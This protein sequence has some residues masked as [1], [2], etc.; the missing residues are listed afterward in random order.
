MSSLTDALA[1][2]YSPHDGATPA[3]SLPPAL[4]TAVL[5]K[6]ASL[7]A[8]LSAFDGDDGAAAEAEND[9]VVAEVTTGA[10]LV[11]VLLA[12]AETVEES[13]AVAAT[14]AL[15][16]LV[17]GMHGRLADVGGTEGDVGSRTNAGAAAASSVGLAINSL[18]AR[19]VEA[20]INQAVGLS[21]AVGDGGSSAP[22]PPLMLRSANLN[23]TLTVS[24]PGALGDIPFACDTA[25]TPVEV[26]LP[27]GMIRLLSAAGQGTEDE[28]VGVVFTVTNLRV[29]P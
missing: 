3:A 23:L 24:E 18:G 1:L 15:N 10:K 22:P 6:V 14:S 20:R 7:A 9:M 17:E 16:S 21:A 19:A 12:A 28:P 25:S 29:E 2:L 11:G 4:V 8:S 27:Q 26:A 5:D 13:T